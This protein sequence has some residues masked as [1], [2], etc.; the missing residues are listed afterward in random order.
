MM[1]MMMM[2]MNCAVCVVFDVCARVCACDLVSEQ[3]NNAAETDTEPSLVIR[4]YC[5]K[6]REKNKV[7]S[8]YTD[9]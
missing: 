3:Q 1:M 5:T 4:H 9:N 8:N 6:M 2:M 7:I